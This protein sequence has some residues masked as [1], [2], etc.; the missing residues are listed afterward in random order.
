MNRAVAGM[1][2][3]AVCC[4]LVHAQ[5]A[6]DARP[7][8]AKLEFEVASVK[9]SA[10]AGRGLMKLDPG[11]PGGGDPGRLTYTFSTIRDLMV[12]AYGVKRYQISGAPNWLDSE[13]FD[14][15]AKIP[16]GATKEQVTGMLQN[17]LAERFRLTL[18]RETRDLPIYALVVG[19]KGARLKESTVAVPSAS[20]SQPKE[21]RRQEAAPPLPLPPGLRKDGTK[22]GPDGCPEVSAMAGARAGNFMIMTPHGACMISSGQTMDGL[23]T[24]LSNRFDRPVIDQTGLKGK[25]DWRLRYDPSDMPEGRGGA[26]RMKDGPGPEPAG[27]DPPNRDG[28]SAPG[29]F[30]ALQEQLGL[31]LEARKGPVYILVID[32]VEKTPTEN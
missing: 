14:V 12:E 25:Y 17:L 27:G 1:V 18:H 10:R 21:D 13:R 6:A 11:G 19:A 8:E 24:Q 23:A 15:V 16:A 26:I 31:R 20:D 22:I 28:D 4:R 5:F 3:V 9:P 2:L 30:N 32:H 7:A 29:F